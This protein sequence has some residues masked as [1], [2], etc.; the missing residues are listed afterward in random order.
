MQ[1]GRNCLTNTDG[2][3]ERAFGMLVPARIANIKTA[4]FATDAWFRTT[5]II[6][7][8]LSEQR[9]IPN[10][11]VLGLPPGVEHIRSQGKYDTLIVRRCNRGRNNISCWTPHVELF[12]FDL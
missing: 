8:K 1:V 11:F 2:N 10:E 12:N 9:I 7:G 4:L 6:Y 3:Q 5:G